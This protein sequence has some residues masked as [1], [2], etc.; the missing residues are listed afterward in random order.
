MKEILRRTWAEI[1][2]DVLA[3]DFAAVRQA[4]NKNAKVCCVIKADAYGHGAVRMAQE[5]EALGADWFAVSNL[6]EA[7]QLRLGGISRPMLVLGYTPPEEAATL[8]KHR[9]SQCV[10]SLEYAQELSHYAV[11]AGATVNIHVKIDTGMSRLGFYFQD[12]SRDEATVQEVKAA[13]ALPGL[14]PEGIFTHF[15]VSDEGQAGDAFTMRQFGCFKEMIE[16]LLREGISFAVRHCANS[17]AVFDYPLSHLDMVRAGTILYGQEG[18]AYQK[19]LGGTLEDGWSLK[20][21]VVALEKLPKG[22]GV[23]YER[24]YIT[25]RPTTVAIVPVGYSHGVGVEPVLR[26]KRLK[27]ALKSVAKTMLRYV[28]HPR[29]RVYVTGRGKKMPILGK[30]AMQLLM[31]DA[32]DVPD[33]AVGDVVTVPARRTTINGTLPKVYLPAAEAGDIGQTGQEFTD[34]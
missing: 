12:I 9:I 14:Y 25:K 15:A 32:T 20:A 10:Y 23:G 24:A 2:L 27:D 21:R 4:A 16:S 1:D 33:L 26:T 3:R 17:A 29:M 30:V 7:L 6:E 8:A 11:E 13:C 28:D 34:I 5:F 22:H 18:E 31:A 19:Q